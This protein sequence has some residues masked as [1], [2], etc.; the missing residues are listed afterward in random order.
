MSATCEAN[1][2]A[3]HIEYSVHNQGTAF[4]WLIVDE[5]LVF[6]RDGSRVELCYARARMQPN[7]KVF[8]YF[9]PDVIEIPAGE[10]VRQAVEIIWPCRLSGIWNS[11]REANLPPGKYEVSVRI[12]FAST[13]APEPPTV[14]EDVESPVLRWQEEATSSPVTLEIPAWHVVP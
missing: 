12:G 7:V 11:E 8:G 3:W 2:P 10:T 13:V 1:P 9:N 4:L 14:G 5:S 6:R